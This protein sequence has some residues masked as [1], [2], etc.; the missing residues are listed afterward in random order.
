MRP[1]SFI[2]IGIGV[3]IILMPLIVVSLNLSQ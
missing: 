3:L 2:A 1:Q